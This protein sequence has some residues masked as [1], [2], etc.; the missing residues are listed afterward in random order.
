MIC[1]KGRLI[2]LTAL[3]LA[4]SVGAARAEANDQ[5]VVHDKTGQIVRVGNGTCVRTKWDSDRDP[6]APQRI[7]QQMPTQQPIAEPKKTRSIAEFTRE[8]RTVYF[9]FDHFA[10]LPEASARLSTLVNTLKTDQTIKEARVVG[11]ADRIGSISYNDKL[12]QKRAETVRDF[13]IANG[14]T[15]AQVTKTRWV[16]KSEPSTNCRSGEAHSKLIACL[17]QDRRVEIGIGLQRVEQTPV[18]Q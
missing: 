11:Y 5:D 4:G 14:Y 7:A 1:H 2:A 3:A 8:D 17:Q 13:L 18:A 16:G 10:L 6:C 12:S 9:A 15:N